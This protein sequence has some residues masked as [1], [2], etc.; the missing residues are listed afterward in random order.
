[1]IDEPFQEPNFE[2]AVWPPLEDRLHVELVEIAAS[3]PVLAGVVVP[4]WSSLPMTR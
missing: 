1:L 2:V 4:S 3:P